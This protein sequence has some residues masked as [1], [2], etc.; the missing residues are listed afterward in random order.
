VP[1]PHIDP[2]DIIIV[3]RSRSARTRA[4]IKGRYTLASRRNARGE[5]REFACRTV[6]ISCYDIALMGPIAGPVGE[7]VIAHF[8]EFGKLEGQIIRLTDDGFVMSLVLTPEQRGRLSA[9]IHWLEMRKHLNVPDGRIHK[10]SVPKKPHSRLVCADGSVCGCFVIDMSVSGVAVSADIIP[11]IGD[12]LAVGSV[13]GRVVRL[14]PEG[15]AVRFIE[16]Q[17]PAALEHLLLRL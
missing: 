8:D 14:F 11:K 9:K 10:R 12:V 7:R 16:L 17:D 15:F 6:E 3:D 1:G 2:D 5:R 4:S 13:V